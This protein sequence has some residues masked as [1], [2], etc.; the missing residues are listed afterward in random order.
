MPAGAS[1]EQAVSLSS[2]SQQCDEQADEP[3]DPDL[4]PGSNQSLSATQVR[5]SSAT[6]KRVSSHG[7]SA[8]LTTSHSG[9]PGVVRKPRGSDNGLL[10]SNTT[11]SPPEVL[12]KRQQM[13]SSNANSLH[14]LASRR[15]L[16]NINAIR[17]LRSIKLD[18]EPR[19]LTQITDESFYGHSNRSSLYS[20]LNSNENSLNALNGL[21]MAKNLSM[22]IDVDENT[23]AH[24]NYLGVPLKTL[25][26]NGG[27]VDNR[28]SS[29]S[30]NSKDTNNQTGN[31]PVRSNDLGSTSINVIP[32]TPTLPGGSA[33]SR[34]NRSYSQYQDRTLGDGDDS[35]LSG[36]QSGQRSVRRP[37]GS[38]SLGGH[39]NHH[40]QQQQHY[41]QKS[42]PRFRGG[43]SRLKHMR[44]EE[45]RYVWLSC[46]YLL[47]SSTIKL[48]K[49]NLFKKAPSSLPRVIKIQKWVGQRN[50]DK[51]NVFFLN[52]RRGLAG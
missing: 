13:R 32:P 40:H 33:D 51:K 36:V 49:V 39:N 23:S 10:F 17:F 9:G 29:R 7:N 18:G 8:T 22:V 19:A 21:V 35:S 3:P 16:R 48:I 45:S 15:T 46:C 43:D 47:N 24:N 20:G 41:H 52:R 12:H 11:F 31:S 14:Q 42:P 44:E 28:T 38:Q 6:L 37:S 2:P 27:G 1:T 26:N 4:K 25:S 5:S 34:Q 30:S 50:K